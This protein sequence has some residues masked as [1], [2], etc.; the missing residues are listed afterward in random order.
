M[1]TSEVVFCNDRNTKWKD[2]SVAALV[3]VL[4]IGEDKICALNYEP[5][6]EKIQNMTSVWRMRDLSLIAIGKTVVLKSLALSKFTSL[7]SSLPKPSEDFFYKLQQQ[8]IV[9]IL[10]EIIKPLK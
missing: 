3:V 5:Q 9:K 4:I 2:D 1:K 8:K 7:F 10:F 6:L